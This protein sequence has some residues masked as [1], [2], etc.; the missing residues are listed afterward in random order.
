MCRDF[1]AQLNKPSTTCPVQAI[2]GSARCGRAPQHRVI[3]SHLHI[4][5]CVVDCI[6]LVGGGL[7]WDTSQRHVTASSL[8]LIPGSPTSTQILQS[9]GCFWSVIPLILAEAGLCSLQKHVLIATSICML[10]PTILF[11]PLLSL[12]SLIPPS[13]TSPG[14]GPV[15]RHAAQRLKSGTFPLSLP[16]LKRK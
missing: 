16:P 12:S 11:A 7:V 9:Q 13:I 15:S 10:L 1:T 14:K 6:C 3:N 4:S 8:C 5:L 2:H